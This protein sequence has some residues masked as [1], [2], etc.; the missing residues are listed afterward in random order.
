M[1]TLS[2]LYPINVL[3]HPPAKLDDNSSS[4]M[5]VFNDL[6]G[7]YDEFSKTG[8]VNVLKSHLLLAWNAYSTG[9]VDYL[10]LVKATISLA[11]L[12]PGG[13]AVVPF[14]NMFVDLIWPSLFGAPKADPYAELFKQIMKAVETYVDQQ[15]VNFE[16]N[17]LS[18]SLESL[19]KATVTFQ[20]SIQV[21][22][23][24]GE[25]PSEFTLQ[26]ADADCPTTPVPCTP[27]AR[28]LHDVQEAFGNARGTFDTY[29]PHFK[30]PAL[31]TPDNQFSKDFI[32]VTVPMFTMAATLELMMFQSYIQFMEKWNGLDTGNLEQTQATLQEKIRGYSNDI[33]T[34]Y[35]TYLPTL[36][37]NN[38][39]SINTY[40]R[41]V[42]N[43][44]L[45]VFDIVAMWPTLDTTHYSTSMTLDQTRLVFSDIAG[46]WESE[47]NDVNAALID[48]L[49]PPTLDGA[50]G[51]PN[52]AIDVSKLHYQ[53][54]ELQTVQLHEVK[55]LAQ[56]QGDWWHCFS[57]GI[58]LNVQNANGEKRDLVWYP[59]NQADEY[60]PCCPEEFI[61]YTSPLSKPL[62]VN[63]TT[64]Y[65][66]YN[67]YDYTQINIESDNSKGITAGCIEYATTPKPI[68][69]NN[70]ALAGQ[71]INLFYPVY[72]YDSPGGY[73][74]RY[75]RY[76]YM[77]S[78]VPFD[79]VP[80]N[81]IG[82][83]D[84]DEIIV[85]RGF[86]AEK[87]TIDNIGSLQTVPE[88]INGA[89]A[90]K[91]NFQQ[92]LAI[93]II[94]VTN[95]Y[96]SIRIRYASS[97]DITGYFH[98]QTPAGDS[99]RGSI[100]FPNTQNTSDKMYVTGENG[101]YTLLTV[102]QAIKFSSGKSTIYIQNNSNAD[103][104]LD[105]I[106]VVPITASQL[107][108]PSSAN[109]FTLVGPYTMLPEPE[110][111][112]F[113]IWQT[114]QTC[115]YTPN[116]TLSFTIL[117]SGEFQV[118]D[119]NNNIIAR[120]IEN[121]STLTTETWN[122]PQNVEKIRFV[123]TD[124]VVLRNIIGKINCQEPIKPCT[125]GGQT[126]VD[127]AY[128]ANGE[129]VLWSSTEPMGNCT[130]DIVLDSD[131]I[132]SIATLQFQDNTGTVVRS[133]DFGPGE[134]NQTVS[135]A[136]TTKIV[137]KPTTFGPISGHLKIQVVTN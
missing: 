43:M 16:I 136:S 73:A 49:N 75:Y 67:K 76:G 28:H 35:H 25:H 83:P 11:G 108:A 86:P 41:Y 21:A 3:A 5:D 107:P 18:T 102:A 128:N 130:V 78:H 15:F 124:Y 27:C 36:D 120:R 92:I 23:C 79:L 64:V 63:A 106:E 129:Q 37:P 109:Q 87:G 54:L 31:N 126:L 119:K 38:K 94:S 26:E 40:N 115:A 50:T 113:V 47:S 46:P 19:Q 42:R 57:D 95:G 52:I 51:H 135:V 61:R 101:N 127:R 111:K 59:A 33:L 122:L 29:L 70:E 117:G 116:S 132:S 81:I 2:E 103:L 134:Q 84:T 112:D 60:H 133:I 12:I 123:A 34:A 6:K 44:R 22:V 9:K 98:V 114:S 56:S 71:K 45:N 137:L 58:R 96:Y 121:Q 8:A 100:T 99:N 89:N 93:P 4:F 82:N 14:V 91:L 85:G 131:F 66:T 88:P 62:I 105:R 53:N 69:S 32:A 90:V 110:G 7:A 17:W 125:L 72:S 80:Q 24:Q 77:S 97:S 39:A 30:N 55:S 13:E 1:A 68:S 10:A 20:Q 65:S 118:L 104:F 48:L 74:S